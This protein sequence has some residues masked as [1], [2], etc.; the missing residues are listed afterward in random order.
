MTVAQ[1][2]IFPA[3][4]VYVKIANE[5]RRHLAELYSEEEVL[6]YTQF[7]DCVGVKTTKRKIRCKALI[8]VTGAWNKE[9]TTPSKGVHLV[10]DKLKSNTAT[11]ILR[12]NE[13]SLQFHIITKPLLVR[14]MIYMKVIQIT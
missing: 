2:I 14:Q 5:A 4:S 13:Y 6:K 10:T 11:I 12:I 3:V 8:N 1:V 7:S 9:L